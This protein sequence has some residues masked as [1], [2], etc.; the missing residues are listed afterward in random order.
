MKRTIVATFA[1]L[2]FSATDLP[3]AE[4][5]AMF[6]AAMKH[7]MTELIPQF[8]RSSG[9][10]INIGY[11]TV[12]AIIARLKAGDAID[13]AVVTDKQLPDLTKQG[14]I[15]A[16]GQAVIAK[17]GLGVFVRKG[18]LKPATNSVDELRNTLL[19]SKSIV[20][21]DPKLGDSSGVATEAILERLGIA[22]EMKPKT[23]LVAAGAKGETVVKGDADIGFDQMSNIVINPKIESLGSLP[24]AL[25][26][27]TNYAGGLVAAGK[28]RDGAKAFLAFLTSPQAQAVM[29]SKGFEGL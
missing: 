14:L 2:L 7:V 6:P 3:A 8:E 20:Y 29:K 18:E 13:V 15:S 27:Y 22:T 23:K 28:E 21:G 17:V 25:Q 16:L 12:G 1:L 4:I 24:S 5:K 26:N 11:G 9:R 19:A 10:K